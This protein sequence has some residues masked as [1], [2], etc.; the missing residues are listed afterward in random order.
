MHELSIAHAVVSTVTDALP[1]PT[2]RVLEVHVRVGV[3]SGVV[4]QALEFAYGVAASGT[5]L[6]DSVLVVERVAVSVHCP[7][8]GHDGEL[9][10]PHEFRCPA[11]GWPTGD[12]LTGR[13][14]EVARL[15]VDDDPPDPAGAPPAVLVDRGAP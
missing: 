4:P 8:C 12:L 2:T 14:L 7:A 15:V 11:C 3:L 6:A 13:E 10:V 9:L 1:S 5:P